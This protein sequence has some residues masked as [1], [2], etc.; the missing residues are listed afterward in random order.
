MTHDDYNWP[1]RFTH[2]TPAG[3]RARLAEEVAWSL[4]DA[5][6]EIDSLAGLLET[7]TA[8]RD[9]LLAALAAPRREGEDR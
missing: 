5:Q 2:P 8:E 3:R 4:K 6:A 9:A 1:S 7:V